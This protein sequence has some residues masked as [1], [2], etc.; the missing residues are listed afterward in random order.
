MVGPDGEGG[1]DLAGH[2]AQP[3]D[4]GGLPVGVI[5]WTARSGVGAG[6]PA[7]MPEREEEPGHDQAGRDEPEEPQVRASMPALVTPCL[8]G[9]GERSIRPVSAGSRDSARAGRVSVPRSIAR[10]CITVSG[11]GTAPPASA[12]TR[13]GTTSG[14]AWVNM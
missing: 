11:S 14:T 12:K 10:I 6:M 7:G 1:A 13:K 9:R 4:R 3:R 5:Q 8:R 2:D